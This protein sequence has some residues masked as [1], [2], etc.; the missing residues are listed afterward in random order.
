MK[1]LTLDEWFKK[2][3]TLTLARGTDENCIY[4]RLGIPNGYVL[5]LNPMVYGYHN[6]NSS[7]KYLLQFYT[8]DYYK[9]SDTCLVFMDDFSFTET[10]DTYYSTMTTM[11]ICG[12]ELLIPS[13]NVAPLYSFKDVAPYRYLLEFPV[14]LEIKDK[15]LEDHVYIISNL[16]YNDSPYFQTLLNT[17]ATLDLNLASA[18]GIG[19]L[20]TKVHKFYTNLSTNTRKISVKLLFDVAEK[21]TKGVKNSVVINKIFENVNT[22]AEFNATVDILETCFLNIG[23]SWRIHESFYG[24]LATYFPSVRELRKEKLKKNQT[25]AFNKIMEDIDFININ[26]EKYPLTFDLVQ[27]GDIPLGTFFRKQ[28]DSYF[29]Y[30]DTWELWEAFVARFPTEAIELAKEVS[31]RTTYEKDIMSYFY[32]I[33]HALP[34]YLEKYTGKKWTCS[35]KIVH[36]ANELEPPKP[37]EN[38]VAKTRSALTPTVDNEKNH[39]VVPYVSMS[40]GGYKTQ[41][42]YALDY[43]LFHRGM[44]YKGNVVVNEIEEKLNGRDDY[45]LMWYTLT[46]TDTARGYPTFLIIFERLDDSTRVHFHR[47]HPMRSKNGEYNPIHQWIKGCY[48]WM[49]GNV[50]FERITVQQ[51]DLAFVD[52]VIDDDFS[53]AQ[54]V[55]SFDNHCF[56]RPVKY[57]PYT[58]RDGQNILGY[59]KLDSNTTLKH[60]EHAD[61]FI[62]A[63]E[64]ELRQCRSWEATPTG[65]WVLR[66][67]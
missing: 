67:D 27:N 42:C 41:F 3:E 62:P 25:K 31:R 17:E 66:I 52:A 13:N 12:K 55:N 23:K 58:K 50:P 60:N 21:T 53:S 47:T 30:N 51:G 6:Y 44:S 14:N 28:I 33:L 5:R 38:G 18:K 65:I 56:E 54:E 35:P 48:R 43:N 49:V 37:G 36:S 1:I 20:F 11:R 16:T 61:R 8:E 2:P 26:K 19:N 22:E 46:G 10:S 63:G 57:L 64:Y 15:K 59:F 4:K 45:G 32:F 34:E 7:N 9:E 29:L 39:V 24:R 40:V